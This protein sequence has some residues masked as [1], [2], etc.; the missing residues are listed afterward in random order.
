MNNILAAHEACVKASQ[1]WEAATPGTVTKSRL[2]DAWQNKE[3][4]FRELVEKI[5]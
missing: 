4:K 2:W 1:K 5:K 3:R